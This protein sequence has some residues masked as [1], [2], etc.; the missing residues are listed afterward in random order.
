MGT[1]GEKI[2]VRNYFCKIFAS[3]RKMLNFV[4]RK[5]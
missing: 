1:I 4:K 3:Q 2:V 5:P